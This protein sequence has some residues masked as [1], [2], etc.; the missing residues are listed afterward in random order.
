MQLGSVILAAGAGTRFGDRPKLLAELDGRALL[1]H[2][3][4]AAC[5]LS[6]LQRIVVVLGSDAQRLRDA[7]DFKRAEPIVCPGWNKGMS[8]SLRCGVATLEPVE[9]VM[10]LLGDAPTVTPELLRRFVG[11][12]AGARAVYQGAPGH[13]VV[14]GRA[15]L[16]RLAGIEG[17]RGVR[18]LLT[19]GLQIECGDLASGADVDTVDD[20]SRLR[21]SSDERP[22]CG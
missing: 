6:E 1:A 2:V 4:E 9:R 3:I 21:D 18:Q 14:L 5:A 15:Q 7:I 19:D 20:L 17:D 22:G 12:A 16:D 8:E 10:V 13:P 11:A